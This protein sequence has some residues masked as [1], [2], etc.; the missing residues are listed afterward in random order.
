M[1]YDGSTES[2]TPG[3]TAH[4]PRHRPHE[5]KRCKKRGF[6]KRLSLFSMWPGLFPMWPRATGKIFVAGVS[7]KIVELLSELLCTSA[8][9][10]IVDFLRESGQGVAEKIS[11]LLRELGTTAAGS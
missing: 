11:E 2:D 3:N 10:T 5:L 1:Y 8:P 6:A 9:E 4:F 7:E